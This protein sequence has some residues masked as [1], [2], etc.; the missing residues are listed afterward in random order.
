M[1]SSRVSPP[2]NCSNK[3]LF[4]I[5]VTKGKLLCTVKLRTEVPR[6]VRAGC[7]IILNIQYAFLNCASDLS[8][9]ATLVSLKMG[10]LFIKF[11]FAKVIITSVYLKKIFY[12]LLSIPFRSIAMIPT[13][14]QNLNKLRVRNLLFLVD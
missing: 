2:Q 13:K 10:I 5:P 1:L 7:S 11:S 4:T 9:N 6:L 3:V 14:T 12:N 8:A